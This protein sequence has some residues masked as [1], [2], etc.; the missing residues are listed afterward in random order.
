MTATPTRPEPGFGYAVLGRAST[1][2]LGHTV[3]HFVEKPADPSEIIADG[4]RWNMRQFIGKAGLFLQHLHRYA[5]STLRA[6]HA[7]LAA[8]Q[9]RWEFTELGLY[10]DGLDPLP[11]DR[12]VLEHVPGIG[13]HFTGQWQDLGD[14]ASW[15]AFTGLDLE[16]YARQPARV[17]RP[18]G[19]FEQRHSANN[20]V[21]KL[22]ILYPGCRLSRQR[23]QKRAEHC[24]VILGTAYVELDDKVKRLE[25]SEKITI[26][27]KSWH[28]LANHHTDILI[29]KEIQMGICDENDIERTDDDYGRN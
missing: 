2:H 16:H 18:W 6:A 8:S 4:G 26:P 22:L 15:K 13:V 17:D 9:Q 27:A 19:Y 14:L 21:H 23:H 5:P 12:A 11:F 7:A 28:R 20:E 10:P 25:I 1:H 24:K 29:I 3:T